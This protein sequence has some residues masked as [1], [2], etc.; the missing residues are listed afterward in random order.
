MKTTFDRLKVVLLRTYHVD[1]ETMTPALPL[2]QLD[3]DSLG[4]GLMLFDAED[5][6]GVK[7]TAAPDGLRTVGDVVRYIDDVISTHPSSSAVAAGA[8]GPAARGS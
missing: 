8:T 5:E 7:F 6:F 4:I 2:E 3:I 1:A